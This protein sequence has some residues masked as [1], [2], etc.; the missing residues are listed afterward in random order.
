MVLG[1]IKKSEILSWHEANLGKAEDIN[2]ILN[3][4]LGFTKMVVDGNLL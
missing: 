1:F 4:S 2:G 3:K